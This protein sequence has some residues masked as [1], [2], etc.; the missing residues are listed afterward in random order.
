MRAVGVTPA[1]VEQ[2]RRA[3]YKLSMKKLV[4]L[5]ANN[6]DI[7]EL[8]SVPPRRRARRSRREPGMMP[9]MNDQSAQAAG[10]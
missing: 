8:R 4:E 10:S 7:D 6:I 1:Y 2:L 3:G 5:R 9:M